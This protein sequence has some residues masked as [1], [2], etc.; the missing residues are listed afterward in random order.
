MTGHS[1]IVLVALSFSPTFRYNSLCYTNLA[2]VKIVPLLRDLFIVN[3]CVK[4]VLM[5]HLSYHSRDS[6]L[7]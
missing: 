7:I 4:K 6:S 2:E 1:V 5:F 3:E